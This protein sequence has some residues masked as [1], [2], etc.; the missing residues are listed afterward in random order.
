MMNHKLLA[1]HPIG[2]PRRKWRQDNFILS[3][4][5]PG[6]LTLE[7]PN[8]FTR[9][10]T[11]RGVKTA[12]DAGFNV[13]GCLWASSTTAMDIVRTAEGFDAAVLFQDLKRFGG[14]GHKNIFCKTNDYEGAM[15][16]TAKWKSV[17]GYIVWDEPI[18][19]EHLAETRRMIDYCERE[20]PDVL[21]YTVANPDYNRLCYWGDNA[22]VPYIE[23]FLDV[24]DPAQ[25]SFDYYPIGRDEYDP[26]LQLDNSTMWSN[27]EVV[28]TAAQRRDVPF[29]FYY[30]GHHFPWH[31]I[32][33]TLTFPMVRS[34]AYAGVLYGAKALEC[35]AEFDGYVDPATGGKGVFFEE[36]KKLNTELRTLGNTLMALT[37]QRVIHDETL[38]PDHPTMEGL[39]T[40]IT[41][42]KLISPEYRLPRRISISEHTDAYGNDY[43]MVLNR[44]Y[45]NTAHLRL[46]FKAASHV[47]EVSKETGE[48]SLQHHSVMRLPITLAPGDLALYRIAPATEEPCTIEYYLEK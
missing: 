5:T 47:Y 33:Y 18:F 11:R 28:R 13:L 40:P 31:K 34:M 15:R 35:Y 7:E 8:E 4:A 43:L 46:N 30:Q 45:D 38:L 2:N 12:V 24:I 29:W 1:R 42:S 48:Q 36:H 20:Y 9:Q 32:D 14:M 6:P 17:K 3:L 25:M 26:A 41:E 23:R 27:L 10:K 21:P 39:R 22:Y 37:C 44:D 19:E 16:D